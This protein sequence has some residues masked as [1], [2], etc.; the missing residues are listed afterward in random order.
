M[1]LSHRVERVSEQIREEVS[2]I[3]ATEVADPGVGLVTV[4]RV[5]VTA[6]LSLARVYWTILGDPT[7]RKQTE[8]ALTR[9][10]AYVRHLLSQRMSLR[11]S[12]EVTFTFDQ[13]AADQTRVEEI[14]FELKKEEEARAIEPI[15]GAAPTSDG[16]TAAEPA[17]SPAPEKPESV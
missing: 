10:A 12:P 17:E 9:A 5:K 2:Q 16:A 8:K 11:R 6:D 14:L 13:A 3:L 4:T 7:Q 1:P 15:D